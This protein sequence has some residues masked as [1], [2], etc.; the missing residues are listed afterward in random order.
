MSAA[1][2]ICF[3]FSFFFFR[4]TWTGPSVT[5][6]LQ[7]RFFQR[8][9]MQ[10]WGEKETAEYPW[11]VRHPLHYSPEIT[12][13]ILCKLTGPAGL[14]SLGK[15]AVFFSRPRQLEPSPLTTKTQGPLFFLLK[16]ACIHNLLHSHPP[17]PDPVLAL[18]LHTHSSWVWGLAGRHKY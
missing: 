17:P 1:T 4:I 7:E 5:Y 8:Y 15:H 13:K 16:I 9:R 11:I 14:T 18:F 2:S 12:S 6:N 3:S 10:N